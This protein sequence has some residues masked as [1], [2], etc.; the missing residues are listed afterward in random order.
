MSGR[1]HFAM[2][3]PDQIKKNH[4]RLGAQAFAA[5]HQFTFYARTHGGEPTKPNLNSLVHPI[6]WTDLE[7]ERLLPAGRPPG[8]ISYYFIAVGRRSQT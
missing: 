6:A 8:V 7:R 3:N 4:M 2:R 1:A 5:L